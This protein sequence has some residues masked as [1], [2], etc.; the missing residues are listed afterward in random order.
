MAE[1]K[2]ISDEELISDCEVAQAVALA[3]KA[4]QEAEH[5]KW[6]AHRER[7]AYQQELAEYEWQHDGIY[8]FH[9]RVT[10]KSVDKLLHTLQRWHQQDKHK[11]WTIYLN[12]VGGEEYAGWAAIDE[13]Q[14]HSLRGGGSH[15]ITIK[16]RGV[17]ASMGAM[18]FQAGDSR[19]MGAGARLMI[20]KGSIGMHGTA[21][22]FLDEAEWV[23]HATEQ[24][25]H[26]FVGR[27][28]CT[29][30][31]IMS[32]IHRRDWWLPATEAVALG[33]ADGIG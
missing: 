4:Q 17:A 22:E 8:S 2:E 15:A 5:V 32:M 23:K 11:P 24:M 27:S 18:I 30:E 14:S 3:E 31:R 10:Q 1:P 16:V 12:S 28:N 26:L 20:H 7:L 21:D 29:R 6:Q 25:V 9:R 13:L 33:F 19:L